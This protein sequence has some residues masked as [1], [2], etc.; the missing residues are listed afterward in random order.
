MSSIV[1]ICLYGISV[2]VDI[3]LGFFNS[4][5]DKLIT[6]VFIGESSLKSHA[7]FR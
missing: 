6:Q 2:E 3:E 1:H 7:S 4:K 5:A